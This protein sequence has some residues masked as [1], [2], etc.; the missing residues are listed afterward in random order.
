MAVE[1]CFGGIPAHVTELEIVMQ[2]ETL[3]MF[4]VLL[5]LVV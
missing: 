4:P 5:L 1:T 2:P 3:P